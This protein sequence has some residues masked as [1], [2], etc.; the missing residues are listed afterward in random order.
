MSVLGAVVAAAVGLAR[1]DVEVV[2]VV[3]AA[4]IQL[5]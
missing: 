2:V 5:D 4:Q 3:V 1:T